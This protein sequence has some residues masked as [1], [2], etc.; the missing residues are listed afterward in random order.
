MKYLYIVFSKTHS[1]MGAM[2][3]LITAGQYNHV[4]VACRENLS[5]L[6]S[7]A[8][9]YYKT[10]SAVDLYMRGWSATAQAEGL[11]RCLCAKS[12]WTSQRP[13]ASGKPST[14]W[15]HPPTTTYT[16]CLLPPPHRL[17]TTANALTAIPAFTLD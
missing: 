9:R 12:R 3:R 17:S 8:R 7:F 1:R 6:V 4:S 14:L 10:P 2:I 13:G 16:I 11:R 15:K 5:D